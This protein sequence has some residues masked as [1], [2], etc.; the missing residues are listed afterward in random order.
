MWCPDCGCERPENHDHETNDGLGWACQIQV[1]WF[2][3]TKQ[4]AI[5][6]ADSTV[7]AGQCGTCGLMAAV[8]SDEPGDAQVMV[9]VA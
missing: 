8:E 5:F 6:P 2:C 3:G 4:V 9:E 7:L 1:C